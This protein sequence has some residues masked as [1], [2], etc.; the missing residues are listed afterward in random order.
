MS[1]FSCPH[2]DATSFCSRLNVDCIPGRKGCVLSRKVS[3][4]IP[5]NKR[6]LSDEHEKVNDP[7][8]EYRRKK[9]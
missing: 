2:I 1:S 5:A 6:K 9:K 3:F 7:F 4:A 8:K